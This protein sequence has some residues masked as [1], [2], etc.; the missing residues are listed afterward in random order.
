MNKSAIRISIRQIC[1]LGLGEELLATALVPAVRELIKCESGAVS[2]INDAGRLTNVYA[3][4]LSSMHLLASIPSRCATPQGCIQNFEADTDWGHKRILRAVVR[5]LR[6]DLAEVSLYRPAS[7]GDFAAESVADFSSVVRYISHGMALACKASSGWREGLEFKDSPEEALVITDRNGR[8]KH[9]TEEGRRMLLLAAGRK[10]D[11]L[12]LGSASAIVSELLG[13]VCDQVRAAETTGRPSALTA[14]SSTSW[15]RFV[16]T[17]YPLGD[18][19]SDG[20]V[21]IRIQRQEPAMINVVRAISRLQL[22]PQQ[23]QIALLI[24]QGQGNREIASS[25]G[26]SCNTVAYH[27]RQ[28]FTRLGVHD[29][30]SLIARI[31]MDP[32]AGAEIAGRSLFN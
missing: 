2:W 11:R 5:D 6:G 4:R 26:V 28:L 14:V 13:S 31:D 1:C 10:I 29:R 9:G 16:L 20:L 12:A 8:L 19:T 24:A 23:R 3:D 17:A 15:G 22:S 21:G 18:A 27:I 32:E 7:Q 30:A 25:M